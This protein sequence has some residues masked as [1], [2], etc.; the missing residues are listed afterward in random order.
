MFSGCV[1][2]KIYT[3]VFDWFYNVLHLFR[4]FNRG[5]SFQF[6]NIPPRPKRVGFAGNLVAHHIRL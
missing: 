5:F 6:L 3:M 4:V 1:S 2:S